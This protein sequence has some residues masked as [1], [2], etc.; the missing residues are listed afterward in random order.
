M[1]TCSKS[2]VKND[3]TLPTG[4]PIPKSPPP[5]DLVAF[6]LTAKGLSQRAVAKILKVSQPTVLRGRRKTENWIA[7]TFPSERGELTWEQRFQVAVARQEIFL[8]HQQERAQE[9]FERSCQIVTLRRVKTKEYPEG[10]KAGGPIVKEILTDEV[11]QYKPSAPFWKAANQAGHELA[12]LSAGY[13]GPGNGSISFAQRVD[14]HERQ[15]NDT[16]INSRS[17][18]INELQEEVETL[19]KELA[20]KVE[21]LVE[22]QNASLRELAPSPGL[23]VSACSLNQADAGA[24]E[25]AATPVGDTTYDKLASSDS[26]PVQDVENMYHTQSAEPQ[27]SPAP[28]HRRTALPSRRIGSKEPKKLQDPPHPRWPE[29]CYREAF[30]L[31][32]RTHANMEG[33][34]PHMVSSMPDPINMTPAQWIELGLPYLLSVDRNRPFDPD[35]PF[36][37]WRKREEGQ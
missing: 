32:L 22:A 4:V 30:D 20:E 31:L 14:V 29:H 23:D 26:P 36:E 35:E 1:A 11:Q 15:R 5:R 13:L 21:A 8:R 28:V 6:Q 16:A 34:Q 3:R 19:K 2:Y 33:V 10:R 27:Y 9:E 12:V 25:S 37:P 18:R 7:E 17:R 24:A